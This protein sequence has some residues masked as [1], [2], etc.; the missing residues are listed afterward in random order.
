[1]VVIVSC[2]CF[3]KEK[4]AQFSACS[5]TQNA[6]VNMDPYIP[7]E[8]L[9]DQADTSHTHIENDSL[10]EFDG[11]EV[12]TWSTRQII[13]VISLSIL[14]VG[15]LSI[16][17]LFDLQL[18]SCFSQGSQVPLYFTGGVLSYMAADLGGEALTSSSWIPVCNTLSVAVV[19]PFSG[20]LTDLFGRRNITLIGSILI[21]VGLV[22]VATA[23][24]FA[25][26]IA[27]MSLAGAGAGIG[28][29]TALGGYGYKSSF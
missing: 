4:L 12:V 5:R 7:D 16:L 21:M 17:T 2:D 11:N 24:S 23:H 29:L 1:M 8:K 10:A 3:N 19:A 28:E 14:W 22:L 25:Q 13:A 15:E 18:C 26:A 6:T 27:G 9:S 20:H